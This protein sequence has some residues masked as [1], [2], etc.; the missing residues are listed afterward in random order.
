M[1]T[2]ASGKTAVLNERSPRLLGTASAFCRCGILT[3]VSLFTLACPEVARAEVLLANFDDLT[4]GS[5]GK[6]FTDGGI[7]FSNLNTAG[8][9]SRSFAI[10]VGSDG[11]SFSPPNYLV[12]GI[13]SPQPGLL[14]GRFGSMDITFAGEATTV[15]LD[16]FARMGIT[17]EN[18][19][20]LQGLN[21][22]GVVASD[23]VIIS[24][25][26]P[27][28]GP[29]S[30][31]GDFDSVRLV[32]SGQYSQGTVMLGVDNVS[33]TIIPEPKTVG[34]LCVG[35]PLLCRRFR[36]CLRRKLLSSGAWS[37]RD[38]HNEFARAAIW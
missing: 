15:S 36:T 38:E 25:W 33:V 20:T 9:P 1:W 8:G 35:V 16:V 30:V 21:A 23:T 4:M 34:L 2:D 22:G 26:Y 18:F 27:Y 31:S 14:L 32:A 13:Y 19:L 29:L 24:Y 12:F 17:G 10:Q 37:N 28:D 7:T 11:A 6:S 5:V 3:F